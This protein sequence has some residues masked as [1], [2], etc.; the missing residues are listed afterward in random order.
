MIKLDIKIKETKS[1]LENTISEL[2]S[3]I[4]KYKTS[5]ESKKEDLKSVCLS[6]IKRKKHL[7]L[8]FN[9]L[10]NQQFEIDHSYINNE[11]VKDKKAIV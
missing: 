9:N 4:F 11:Y 8:R 5:D 6:L 1:R 7:E 10:N 3:S 2:K